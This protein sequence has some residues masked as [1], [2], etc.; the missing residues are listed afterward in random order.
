MQVF[1][2][3]LEELTDWDNYTFDSVIDEMQA[4]E[5]VERDSLMRA[6]YLFC[7]ELG[8]SL[9]L[10]DMPVK[11]IRRRLIGFT[12]YPDALEMRFM[13]SITLPQPEV[14]EPE[15]VIVC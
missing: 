15:P 6:L 3:F 10:Y 5:G 1:D 7:D 4:F 2:I 9:T 11:E 13:R 8:R 12:F 14:K